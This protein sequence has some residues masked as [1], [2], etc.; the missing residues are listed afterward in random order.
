LPVVK[1]SARPLKSSH[2]NSVH[3]RKAVGG[4]VS[5]VRGGGGV[6]AVCIEA[7][8]ISLARYEICRSTR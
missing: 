4:L 6:P 2:T 7:F 1:P 5:C 8:N 3:T